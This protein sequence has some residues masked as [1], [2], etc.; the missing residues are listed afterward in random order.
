MRQ[1]V[2]G[3]FNTYAEADGARNTLVQSGFAYQ[4]VELR[5]N[6]ETASDAIADESPGVLANIERF[7]AS[8]FAT[9]GSGLNVPL[10]ERYADAVRRGAVLVCVDA[11]SDAQTELAHNTLVRLGAHDVSTQM[12]SAPAQRE[13]VPPAQARREHSMLD[14]LGIGGAAAQPAREPLRTTDEER[15]FE[16]IDAPPH[17]TPIDDE[18]ARTALAAGGA[19]GS[20]AVLRPDLADTGR[21]ELD[22]A[23]MREAAMSPDAAMPPRDEFSRTSGGGFGA[24]MSQSTGSGGG[25]GAMTQQDWST[26]QGSRQTMTSQDMPPMGAA[27][28]ESAES[29]YPSRTVRGAAQYQS[30]PSDLGRATSLPGQ[31]LWQRESMRQ[32]S[33]QTADRAAERTAASY[34]SAGAASQA[35]TPPRDGR[36]LQAGVGSDLY[37]DDGRAADGRSSDERSLREPADY[38]SAASHAGR[39]AD[40]STEQRVTS[41]RDEHQPPQMAP[42][43][44][45]PPSSRA[46]STTATQRENL[47]GAR[48]TGIPGER[49]ARPGGTV[50][51]SAPGTMNE[52]EARRDLRGSD[53]RGSDYSPATVAGNAARPPADDV[54]ATSG[55]ASGGLGAPIPDEFLE[56]EEDFRMHYD[57][58]YG[59]REGARYDEYVP[60]YRY[61]ATMGRD[62]RYQDRPWDED[63]ELEARHDWERAAP[64]GSWD[65]FKAAV[66]HGWERVTGHHP[67]HH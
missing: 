5:A 7:F 32:R 67:H 27:G 4:G 18:A 24:G 47:A 64:E 42:D 54:R 57:E 17:D 53:L 43:I 30:D 22:E 8:L 23:A 13:N 52:S 2:I 48:D 59:T 6:P 35:G 55:T 10:A 62:T 41:M 20:G 49:V 46:T 36:D 14:E 51:S 58:Q 15:R 25:M 38:G 50:H 33:E 1:T 9:S 12:N 66:R 39:T 28:D 40:T 19:P 56:Y 44:D 37:S 11:Q 26:Q 65:R 61:G 16:R 29:E 34:P 60:A 63:V 45:P 3:L 31:G 21:R